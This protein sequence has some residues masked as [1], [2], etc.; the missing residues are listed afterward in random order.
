M[1]PPGRPLAVPLCLGALLLAAAAAR[2]AAEEPWID[3]PNRPIQMRVQLG[4]D[5]HGGFCKANHWH[6]LSV[7]LR[8][9][10]DEVEGVLRVV[11]DGPADADDETSYSLPVKLPKN[12]KKRY[13]L[14]TLLET[15][16]KGVTVVF[17]VRRTEVVREVP[18]VAIVGDEEENLVAIGERAPVFQV[19]APPR[20]SAG[21]M[22]WLA[23]RRLFMPAPERLPESWIAYSAIDGVFLDEILPD[24]PL[25][26][27]QVTA[28]DGYCNA[29]GTLVVCVGKLASA[30]T[31]AKLAGTPWAELLPVVVRGSRDVDVAAA[32]AAGYGGLPA[33]A[34]RTPLLTVADA[35]VREGEVW[36]SARD[37]PTCPLVVR[38][39]RG[40]G[41][42]IFCAFSPTETVLQP[43]PGRLA[44]LAHL[45]ARQGFRTLRQ[46]WSGDPAAQPFARPEWALTECAVEVAGEYQPNNALQRGAPAAN[47]VRDALT[48]LFD[49]D[50]MLK[51]PGWQKVGLFL[52]AYILVLVPVNSA[53]FRRLGRQEW[54][55]ISGLGITLLFC[56]GAFR[57]GDAG[58]RAQLTSVALG[59]LEAGSG[60][61]A[62]PVTTVIG[63]RSSSRLEQDVAF[64]DVL[65][66]PSRLHRSVR[67]ARGV[68]REVFN[69]DLAGPPALRGFEMLA[70]ETCRLETEHLQPL[71]E[72]IRAEAVLGEGLVSV[73]LENGIN[74]T[75]R[76]PLVLA[77]GRGAWALADLP[78]GARATLD[79]RAGPAGDRKDVTRAWKERAALAC[80]G[81]ALQQ[82]IEYALADQANRGDHVVLGWL[83]D[84][85]TRLTM[86]GER[87][88]GTGRTLVRVP[89]DLRPA[90]GTIEL[91]PDLWRARLDYAPRGGFQW[92]PDGRFEVQGAEA[93]AEDGAVV[94]DLYPQVWPAGLKRLRLRIAVTSTGGPGSLRWRPVNALAARGARET[95]WQP[96]GWADV[97][98]PENKLE[99]AS[100]HLQIELRAERSQSLSGS[101]RVTLWG[102]R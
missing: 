32:L 94:L 3:D 39:R 101:L 25:T 83:D 102:T 77:G 64:P 70:N 26:V 50:F 86:G 1:N 12:S 89:L 45:V 72:G 100:G 90:E 40:L 21:Q 63:L 46:S 42:V 56:M 49:K 38:A 10:G 54:A 34:A 6:P 33:T 68:A 13:P 75:L 62:G 23:P 31:A 19:L 30:W 11:R 57:L 20:T 66:Y 37:A 47:T 48:S 76:D 80:P 43:L 95:G 7:E 91:A 61:P 35:T 17:L 9:T 24:N 71:G 87:V 92:L 8:N 53:V 16:D 67:D 58:E 73:A 15:G 78:S 84:P 82:L 55:W 5:P 52:V 22:R 41:Q 28:L 74:T 51:I 98:D 88:S 97:S 2:L 14:V 59:V 81:R 44:L 60:A 79:P 85:V 29:G 99:Q 18:S 4:F 96:V 65:T 36:L 69:V 93:G 27:A